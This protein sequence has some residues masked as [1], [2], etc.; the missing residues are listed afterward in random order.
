MPAIPESELFL[1]YTR[2]NLLQYFDEDLHWVPEIERQLSD[3]SMLALATVFFGTEH[4][5]RAVVQRGL[6]KYSSVIEQLNAALGDP[7][8][9]NSSDL[10]DAITTMT[11]LEV[12]HYCYPHCFERKWSSS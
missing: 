9:S 7:L 3:A 12:S 5:D 4:Q 11:L 1:N 10:F 2:I 8:R 6:R